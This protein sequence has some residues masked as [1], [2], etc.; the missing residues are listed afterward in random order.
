MSRREEP[1]YPLLTTRPLLE[2][3]I[4]LF[5]DGP[6][7]GI[8]PASTPERGG[9]A[10]RGGNAARNWSDHALASDARGKKRGRPERAARR[11]CGA[12]NNRPVFA[13]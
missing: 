10:G 7:M 13:R 2:R 5:E 4:L 12:F 6:K 1:A 3:K 9:M 11:Q 8:R